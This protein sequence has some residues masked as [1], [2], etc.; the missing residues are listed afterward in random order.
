[1]LLVAIIAEATRYALGGAPVSKQG[2]VSMR[3]R[4]AAISAFL[5]GPDAEVMAQTIIDRCIALGLLERLS[6]DDAGRFHVRLVKWPKW[7]PKD[8]S[9]ADRKRRSRDGQ[10]EDAEALD[11]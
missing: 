1:M 6:D 4:A 7:H 11:W 5:P 3:Y 10:P 9:A 2:T 8:A